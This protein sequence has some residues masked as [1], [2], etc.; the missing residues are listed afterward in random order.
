[1]QHYQPAHIGIHEGVGLV[2]GAFGWS[3]PEI[4]C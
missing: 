3:W 1:M 2:K 4:S